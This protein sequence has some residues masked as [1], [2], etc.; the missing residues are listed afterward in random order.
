MTTLG[1]LGLVY[2]EVKITEWSQSIGWEHVL[3]LIAIYRFWIELTNVYC[4]SRWT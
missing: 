4:S 1:M 3:F 2:G